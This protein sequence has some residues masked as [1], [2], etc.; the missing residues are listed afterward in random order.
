MSRIPPSAALL[1]GL[2]VGMGIGITSM[3]FYLTER[4]DAEIATAEKETVIEGTKQAVI[5]KKETIKNTELSNQLKQQVK[6]GE[7]TIVTGKR[8]TDDFT[9]RLQ[10]KI[11]RAQ[12]FTD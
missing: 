2:F 8:F 3:Y 7:K 10:S 6:T 4:L 12:S 5:I 9:N 1:I 11:E